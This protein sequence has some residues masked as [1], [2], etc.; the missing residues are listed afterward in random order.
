[1]EKFD[2]ETIEKIARVCHEANRAYCR[3][4]GDDSQLSWDDSPAW[5]RE[6]ARM[7]VDFHL[8]GD[9]GPEASHISWMKEKVNSGWV[10]GAVKNPAAK[11]HPCL[12]PFS[13]LPVEQQMKDHL[14]RGIVHSFKNVICSSCD[15][16]DLDIV[17]AAHGASESVRSTGLRRSTL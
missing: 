10:Y 6:S 5:Q 16:N 4:L 8:M 7:G 12:V 3:T 17:T 14:F 11:T 15:A 1:M 9:F 13:E 2:R